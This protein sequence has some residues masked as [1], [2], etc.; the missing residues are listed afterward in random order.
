[1]KRRTSIAAGLLVVGLLGTRASFAETISV[2]DDYELSQD[3]I[4]ASSDGDVIDIAPGVYKEFNLDPRGKPITIQ[5]ALNDDGTLTTTIDAQQG[6][7]VFVFDSQEGEGTI[8]RNLVMVGGTGTQSYGF[9]HGGGILCQL[10][11]PTI[12]NC[13]IIGHTAERGGG[14]SCLFSRP[15]I[16]NCVISDNAADVGGGIHCFGSTSSPTI[17]DC[18]ISDNTAFS[19]AGI[20]CQSHSPVPNTP[21]ISGCTIKNNIASQNG[22][23]ILCNDSN[24]TLSACTISGNTANDGGGIF[25][26]SG[27]P[28]I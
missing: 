8:V 22:G 16:D 10:S 9:L 20:G 11:H 4:D 23:G 7:S 13:M 12:S 28:T 27:N 6:G 5:G 1:M 19:G 2:P 26:Y 18:T 3:A 14:I 25:C 17:T 21:I 15:T 24:A